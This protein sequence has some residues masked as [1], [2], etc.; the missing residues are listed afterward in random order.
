MVHVERLTAV[1]VLTVKGGAPPGVPK[2]FYYSYDLTY[3]P[4]L[5]PLPA[6][7][8]CFPSGNTRQSGQARRPLNFHA[9]ADHTLKGPGP[10][11]RMVDVLD[12]SHEQVTRLARASSPTVK[13]IRTLLIGPECLKLLIRWVMSPP[14]IR[15]C[16]G[17]YIRLCRHLVAS[18]TQPVS[19]VPGPTLPAMAERRAGSGPWY[20]PAPAACLTRQLGTPTVVVWE[21]SLQDERRRPPIRR[22]L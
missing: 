5:L 2:H 4:F 21:P 22:C 20:P 7:Q 9:G 17:R 15:D 3:P 10:V 6:P 19:A 8:V 13:E 14:R 18:R 16:Q 1:V 11:V 12:S